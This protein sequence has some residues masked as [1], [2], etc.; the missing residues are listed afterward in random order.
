MQPHSKHRVLKP[1][2]GLPFFKIA[3]ARSSVHGTTLGICL[4]EVQVL[5]EHLILSVGF[6]PRAAVP[7][8][9]PFLSL[10]CGGGEGGGGC[11]CKVHH[12]LISQD[13]ATI[14]KLVAIKHLDE[15]GC[16]ERLWTMSWCELHLWARVQGCPGVLTLG[17]SSREQTVGGAC[18]VLLL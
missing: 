12:H 15:L 6:V 1:P 8:Q 17:K 4:W 14:N 16:R 9:G 10:R 7:S 2:L 11:P 18:S 3:K 13:C 5:F